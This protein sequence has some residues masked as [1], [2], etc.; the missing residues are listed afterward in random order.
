MIKTDLA[1]SIAEK[2]NIHT[3]DADTFLTTFTNTFSDSLASGEPVRLAG[4]LHL[5]YQAR[6]GISGQEPKD[7]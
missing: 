2:M 5:R 1:R 7:G 3:K 4:I 6:S